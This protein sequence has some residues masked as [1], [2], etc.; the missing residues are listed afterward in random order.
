MSVMASKPM[1]SIAAS[2]PE[3]IN[4]DGTVNMSD[5]ILI[6]SH[7]NT[8]AG[9]ANYDI[10]CD[11]NRDN[12]VNMSDVILI[13]AKFNIVYTPYPT[14][15]PTMKLSPTPT[16]TAKPSPTAYSNS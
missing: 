1:I 3:D 10:K 2:L 8:M 16:Q 5:V 9:N 13:A 11:V 7:F 6:A 15:T 12:A 4:G 14:S